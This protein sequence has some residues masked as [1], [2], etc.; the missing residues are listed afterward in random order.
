[1]NNFV[2][3][4]IPLKMLKK[5]KKNCWIGPRASLTSVGSSPEPKV[6][7]KYTHTVNFFWEKKKEKLKNNMLESYF[8]IVI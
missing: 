5:N 3:T 8:G 2:N 7:K 6:I 4:M 1:M